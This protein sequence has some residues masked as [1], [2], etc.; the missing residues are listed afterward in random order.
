MKAVFTLRF[1]LG[2]QFCDNSRCDAVKK[3]AHS[4]LVPSLLWY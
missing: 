1:T 3:N 2:K 4:I